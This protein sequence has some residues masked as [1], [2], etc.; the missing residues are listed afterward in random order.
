MMTSPDGNQDDS[1]VSTHNHSVNTRPP[2]P[3][4]SVTNQK[5]ANAQRTKLFPLTF[6]YKKDITAR[7]ESEIASA[8]QTSVA[9]ALVGINDTIN[10]LLQANN[11]LVYANL[12]AER[13]VITEATA[14]A[15]SLKVD[16]VVTTAVGRALQNIATP[17]LDTRKRRGAPINNDIINAT[18]YD[19]ADEN[20]GEGE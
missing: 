1:T 17:T 14:T 8:V 7:L 5:L 10:T 12:R 13:D 3:S 15:V 16:A 4:A 9:T 6:E 11:K 19:T 2:S 18:E 20:G